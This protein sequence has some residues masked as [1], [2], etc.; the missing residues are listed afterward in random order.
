MHNVHYI[1]SVQPYS[2]D[3]NGELPR[4]VQT[5]QKALKEANA[6]QFNEV[7]MILLPSILELSKNQF[8]S[9]VVRV[10]FDISSAEQN[11]F[12]AAQLEGHVYSLATQSYACHIVEKALEILPPHHKVSI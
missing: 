1:A 8:G 5:L 3:E 7:F 4:R 12:L 11:L 2:I 6:E 9:Y 10:L